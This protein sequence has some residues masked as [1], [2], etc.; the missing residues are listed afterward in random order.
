M[1]DITATIEDAKSEPV[2]VE[3]SGGGQTG[4]SE[5][6]AASKKAKGEVVTEENAKRGPSHEDETYEATYMSIEEASRGKAQKEASAKGKR[7]NQARRLR[8]QA[9]RRR[10]ACESLEAKEGSL[11]KQAK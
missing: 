3:G 5:G 2:T 1:L 7:R 11:R 10:L 9:A 8:R 4:V 6:T